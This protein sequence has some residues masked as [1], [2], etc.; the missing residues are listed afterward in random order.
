MGNHLINDI[1]SS[2]NNKWNPFNIKYF[3][4]RLLTVFANNNIKFLYSGIFLIFDTIRLSALKIT[5]LRV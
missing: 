2:K 4:L 3:I 5:T 1:V